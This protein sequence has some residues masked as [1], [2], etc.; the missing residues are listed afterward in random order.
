MCMY[1]GTESRTAILRAKFGKFL[2]NL[3]AETLC[4]MKRLNDEGGGLHFNAGESFAS[5]PQ[6]PVTLGLRL[7]RVVPLTN[8]PACKQQARTWIR[9]SKS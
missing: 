2:A 9:S 5:C 7:F 8:S 3:Y 6:P 1:R 4:T